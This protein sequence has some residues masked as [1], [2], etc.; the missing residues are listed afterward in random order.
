MTIFIKQPPVNNDLPGNN[1]KLE[2][3]LLLIFFSYNS[4][5]LSA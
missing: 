5:H 2:S 3:L 4:L 1:N